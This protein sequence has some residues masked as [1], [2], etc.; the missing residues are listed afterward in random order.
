MGNTLLRLRHRLRF[1][2]SP[3]DDGGGG[4]SP[5]DPNAGGDTNPVDDK[6][7]EPEPT[8]WKA[9]ARKWETRAKEN[10]QA[11]AR[12]AEVEAENS[13][14]KSESLRSQVALKHG[15][16]ADDAAMFLTA[17]TEKELDAQ[18]ARLAALA[19]PS[20]GALFDPSAGHTP[21]TQPSDDAAFA[22]ALFGQD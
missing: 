18:A 14:L 10:S 13:L 7:K 12:L 1:I 2:D 19:K 8:D 21:K 17:T 3:S 6:G 9:M 15:I 4:T 20:G 5:A 16:S 11:A 22:A